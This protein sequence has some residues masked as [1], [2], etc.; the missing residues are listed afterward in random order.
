M[1]V[2]VDKDTNQEY[3]RRKMN[4]LM[5]IPLFVGMV[6]LGA[7]VPG[8]DGSTPVE[9]P[10]VSLCSSEDIVASLTRLHNAAMPEITGGIET[11][12]SRIAKVDEK[13]DA[14]IEIEEIINEEIDWW[15]Y[16][17]K[18]RGGSPGGERFVWYVEYTEEESK[19][20]FSNEYYEVVEFKLYW[21][22]SNEEEEWE[23][24]SEK[25]QVR[26]KET[27]DSYKHTTLD[28]VIDNLAK[29]ESRL[30]ANRTDKSNAKEKSI[31]VLDDA[32]DNKDLWEIEEVSEKVYLV[33]GY[34]LGYGEQLVAGNW[35]YYEETESLEPRDS[36]S[37]RLRDILTASLK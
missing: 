17:L 29:E 11:L 30:I 20:Y 32:L 22:W 24:Y 19:Q 28:T 6:L 34:G 3:N 35:Y 13:I 7:C 25:A 12:D 5:L 1:A 31:Q 37:V 4:K 10:K 21:Q 14:L 2:S 26:D 23:T 9:P 16:D 33:K 27:S 15:C 36:A 18:Q 8:T